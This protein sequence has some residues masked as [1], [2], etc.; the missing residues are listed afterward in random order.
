MKRVEDD[1]HLAAHRTPRE[2][3]R[4]T[5]RDKHRPLRGIHGMQRLKPNAHAALPR[6]GNECRNSIGDHLA[7]IFKAKPRAAAHHHHQ[8]I[9]VQRRCLIHGAEV[10][11]DVFP[12]FRVASA[13]ETCRRGKRW[14]RAT[15]HRSRNAHMRQGLPPR[16]CAAKARSTACHAA[17]SLPRPRPRSSWSVVI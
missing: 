6:I 11:L 7:R 4:L 13:R 2:F 10:I 8:R 15:R 1:A 3:Q 17:R 14:K 12:S 9:G 5:D 16:S